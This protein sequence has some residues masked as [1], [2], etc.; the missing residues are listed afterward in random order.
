MKATVKLTWSQPGPFIVL[1][2]DAQAGTTGVELV[3]E[4]VSISEKREGA[5]QRP[6]LHGL[7]SHA[8]GPHADGARECC[9]SKDT[10]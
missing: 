4:I 6:E 3:P 2:T 8:S 9:Y 5:D 1:E 7:S 10:G